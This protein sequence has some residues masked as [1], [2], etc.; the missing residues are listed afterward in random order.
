[1]SEQRSQRFLPIYRIKPNPNQPRRYFDPKALQELSQ[2][3]KQQGVLQPLIVRKHPMLEGYFELVAGER[4]W[5][6]LQLAG[7]TQA[8]SIITKLSDTEA[9]EV[10]L[11]ENIQREDLTP[12]EEGQCY[13]ELMQLHGLTQEELA[14]KLGKD[15]STIANMVRLLA[16]PKAIQQD[17]EMGRLSAGHARAVLSLSDPKEQLNLRERLLLNNWSVRETEKQVKLILEVRESRASQPSKKIG[18]DVDLNT[19]LRSIEAELQ[20]Y[21]GTKMRIDH[22]PPFQGE[23]RLSY[24]SA[25]ELDRLLALLRSAR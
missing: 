15:R 5:R 10:A 12:I 25:E 1:M 13:Y 3:I 11:L 22:K 18:I 7:E 4:R 21:L 24:F 16:L 20:R 2:S 23:I 19:E 6:A 8:P 14:K 17:L 9:L